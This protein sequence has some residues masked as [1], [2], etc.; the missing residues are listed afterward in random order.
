MNYFSAE[1]D[2]KQSSIPVKNAPIIN[3]LFVFI[4]QAAKKTQTQEKARR[5]N[6]KKCLLSDRSP[7]LGQINDFTRI[8]RL[9]L[10][11]NAR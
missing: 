4:C 5:E 11:S 1:K 2:Q 7:S 6:E 8:H 9:L 10:F 3:L